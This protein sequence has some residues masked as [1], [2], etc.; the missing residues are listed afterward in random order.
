MIVFRYYKHYD[1][2]SFIGDLQPVE[3]SE[4]SDCPNENYN[5]L[6]CSFQSIVYKHAP[7]RQI[8]FEAIMYH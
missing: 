4:T 8:L 1:K 2:Q 5:Y 3:L 6:I 7:F